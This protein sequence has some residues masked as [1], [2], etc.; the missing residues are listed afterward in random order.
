MLH[1]LSPQQTSGTELGDF[2]KIV[3]RD[4]HVELH[5]TSSKIHI[6]ASINQ[7]L[8]V[9]VTPSKGITQFLHDVGTCVV[10]SLRMN[11]HDMNLRIVFQQ[12]HD[13]RAFSQHFRD[14]LSLGEDVL[15]GVKAHSE[16]QFLFVE[17]L[18]GEIGIHEFCQFQGMTGTSA[19]VQIDDFAI[20]VFQQ[21]FQCLC[22]HQAFRNTEAQ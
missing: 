6:H 12:L 22:S 18:F 14:I 20:D 10:Q 15:D 5:L 1:N 16:R 2:H 19:E 21:S 9:L 8:Q 17:A 7:L 11:C 4:T 13:F 3:L